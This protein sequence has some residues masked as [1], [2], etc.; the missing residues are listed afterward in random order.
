MLRAEG[1]APAFTIL[2]PGTITAKLNRPLGAAPLAA[3]TG[4]RHETVNVMKWDHYGACAALIQCGVAQMY[5]F[6]DENV[7]QHPANG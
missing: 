5:Q 4:R 1:T 7:N 3:A 2:F 6:G